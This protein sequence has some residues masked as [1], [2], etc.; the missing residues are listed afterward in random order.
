MLPTGNERVSPDVTDISSDGQLL[1]FAAAG[2]VARLQRRL[3]DVSQGR[4]AY[5]AGWAA[6]SGARGRCLPPR[7]KKA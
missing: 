7:S 6:A 2:Q 3:P 1:S 5:A 4:I